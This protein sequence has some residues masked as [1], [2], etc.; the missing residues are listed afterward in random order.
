M[1]DNGMHHHDVDG[2][3]CEQVKRTE[4]LWTQNLLEKQD[5]NGVVY[6]VDEKTGDRFRKIPAG[7]DDNGVKQQRLL[8]INENKL[9][10]WKGKEGFLFAQKLVCYL[11]PKGRYQLWVVCNENGKDT[12]GREMTEEDW[13]SMRM[14][15]TSK[16]HIRCSVCTV[17]N[18]TSTPNLLTNG[19][20]A[21]CFCKGSK[22]Q[23]KDP[24]YFQCIMN[25]DICRKTNRFTQM[26]TYELVKWNQD[27]FVR[28]VS[29][30]STKTKLPLRCKTCG[31]FSDKTALTSLGQNQGIGCFC[32]RSKLPLTDPR[33]FQ[34]MMNTTIC[35]K[36]DQFMQMRKY[37][38]VEWDQSEFILNV[39][40]TGANTKLPLKCKTCGIFSN[41]MTTLGNLQQNLGIACFC[42]GSKLPLND[43]RYFQCMMDSTICEKTNQF[44]QMYK[45]ELV[46]WDQDEFARQVSITSNETKLPLRCKMCG[47]FSNKVTTLGNLQRNQGISCF[48]KGITNMQIADPRYF[49]CMM[50]PAICE[51]TEQFTRMYKYELVGWDQN[52]FTKHVSKTGVKTKLPL[53]CKT[54]GVFS[55]KTVLNHLQ[56]NQG[57]GCFCRGSA[58]ELTDP[59]YYQCMMN[60]DIC[61]ET[62]HFTQMHRHEL[63]EWNQ[64]EFIRQVSKTGTETKLPLRCKTCG[65]FSKKTALSDMQQNHGI[66]CKCYRHK[67]EIKVMEWLENNAFPMATWENNPI[68][69][70]PKSEKGGQ[71]KFDIVGTWPSGIQ[72]IVEVDGAQHFDLEAYHASTD[73]IANDVAKEQWVLRPPSP[74]VVTTVIGL[75]RVLQ[76]DAWGD[77]NDWEGYLRVSIESLLH[78]SHQPSPTP[79]IIRPVVPEYLDGMYANGREKQLEYV[80][81]KTSVENSLC[82]AV[83]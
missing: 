42:K 3:V 29:N 79:R 34:C 17:I 63:M 45:Y 78:L 51:K 49:K 20:G 33:Y 14:K 38:L 54:C 37:E 9:T 82:T 6:Y 62:D 46:K 58:M 72:I 55:N 73:I 80:Q 44:T 27:E 13:L 65:V 31:V 70:G 39:S 52:E 64:D 48:C 35:E 10:N 43:P 5:E 56:Q 36:T 69:F 61:E 28:Q 25:P 12:N 60:P 83:E 74:S 76:E 30:T 40:K 7:V 75:V 21:G 57:I 15:A 24:Q 18:S 67:T 4:P 53:R 47:V 16:L 77:L 26:H 41:K 11:P 2:S 71:C 23:L 50:D 8:P 66:A 59:Q 19:R 68:K 81:W 1:T 22:M 32:K